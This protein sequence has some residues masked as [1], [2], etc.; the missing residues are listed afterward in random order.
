[1]TRAVD[2]AVGAPPAAQGAP[3]DCADR[4]GGPSDE[5]EWRN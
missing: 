1:M 4:R 5:E 2:D 3:P